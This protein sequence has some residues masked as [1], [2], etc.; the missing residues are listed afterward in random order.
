MNI[1]LKSVNDWWYFAPETG[2]HISFYTKKSLLMIAKQF[3]LNLYTNRCDLHLLTTKKNPIT[4]TNLLLNKKI[5]KLI[6]PY[7]RSRKSLIPQDVEHI[8][9]LIH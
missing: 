8:K 1:E 7:L 4:L 3:G 9:Q 6:N 2:Q 5:V